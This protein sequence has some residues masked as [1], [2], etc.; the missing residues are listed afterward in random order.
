MFQQIPSASS[1][2]TAEA[3]RSGRLIRLAA[4]MPDGAHVTTWAAWPST[5]PAI[6]HALTQG[7]RSA[8]ASVV[9][10]HRGAA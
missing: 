5:C 10:H 3:P 1:A 6:D 2:T 4:V 7:A 9:R 8:S